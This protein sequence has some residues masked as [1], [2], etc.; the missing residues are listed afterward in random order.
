MSGQ[1]RIGGKLCGGVFRLAVEQRPFLAEAEYGLHFEGESCC[2]GE[3]AAIGSAGVRRD[4]VAHDFLRRPACQCRDQHRGE[5]F[6]G[7]LVLPDAAADVAAPRCVDRDFRD[8]AEAEQYPADGMPGFMDGHPQAQQHR[9]FRLRPDEHGFK[10]AI[11]ER[12]LLP[13]RLLPGFP[14]QALDIGA[15]QALRF[16]RK[17]SQDDSGQRVLGVRGGLRLRHDFLPFF[18]TMRM[19]PAMRRRTS[20]GTVSK[21]LRSSAS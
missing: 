7:H 14:H 17:G 3:I 4:R 13:P 16:S 1:I 11:A 9:A 10:I 21:T 18:P 15:G 2:Q 6:L 19:L 20:S 8:S 5:L 12:A